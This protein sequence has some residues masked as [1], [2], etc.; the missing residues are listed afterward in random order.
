[1]VKSIEP[2]IVGK[3]HQ[4]RNSSLPILLDMTISRSIERKVSCFAEKLF[5]RSGAAQKSSLHEPDKWA[6]KG[7]IRVDSNEE[8]IF[9]RR[10]C[11][12]ESGIASVSGLGQVQ[13][14]RRAGDGR[15][16]EFG[17]IDDVEAACVVFVENKCFGM[18]GVVS[19][20]NFCA[21]PGRLQF[22]GLSRFDAGRAEAVITEYG[23]P[24]RKVG[25]LEDAIPNHCGIVLV[26]RNDGRQ[27]SRS[28]ERA[29]RRWPREL[30]K[31][32]KEKPCLWR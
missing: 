6:R 10:G 15:T 21:I 22:F 25:N 17:K 19:E 27:Y 7:K 29:F 12:A 26:I 31:P 5:H 20:R 30:E 1:M 32:T 18:L 9:L 3:V 2:A 14:I 4:K 8:L 13:G 23:F 11:A 24:V 16:A 28:G